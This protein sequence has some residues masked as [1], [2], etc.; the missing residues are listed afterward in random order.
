MKRIFLIHGL[1]GTPDNHWFPWLEEEIKDLRLK[2]EVK[3]VK[4]PNP[5]RPILSEW[6]EAIDKAVGEPSEED[7][8]VG[9]SLGCIAIVRWLEKLNTAPDSSATGGRIGGAVFVAGFSGRIDIDGT[10]TFWKEP[11]DFARVKAAAPLGRF[12]TVFSE[13]D[14]VVPLQKGLEFQRGLGA[15]LVIEKNKGHFCKEDG[16]TEL[17]SVFDSLLDMVSRNKM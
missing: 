12:V 17:P 6:L 8:F 10:E 14:D 1:R 4:M 3:A 5:G 9:H 15:K 7:F 11:V 13:D 2:I 16:V